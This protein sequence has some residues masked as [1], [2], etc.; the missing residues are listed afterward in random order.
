MTELPPE[1]LR[2][3]PHDQSA[4]GVRRLAAIMFTDIKDFS[5]RMERDE[6][7][8]M[9]MLQVHNTMMR[10]AVQKFSGVVVKT[11]GDAFL[12]SFN[13][14]VSAVQC[15]VE[16]QQKFHEYNFQFKSDD[17]RILV[18]IG[19]HLGDVIESGT[20]IFG[21]GVN[22]ASRI[23]SIAEVGGLNI[24]ESVYQQVKNKLNIRVINLGVPQLKG[25]SE[26]V[27]LYQVIIVPTDK[28]RGTIATNLYVARTILRRKKT[29]QILGASFAGALVIGSL[30]YFFLAP[31]TLPNSLAILPF[32]N[33]GDSLTDYVVDGISEDLT[34]FAAHKLAKVH[35][36]SYASTSIYKNTTQKEIEIAQK[37][38]VRFLL[39]GRVAIEQN[40]VVLHV[41]LTEPAVNN[42]PW[43]TTY[44]DVKEDIPELEQEMLSDLSAQ[45]TKTVLSKGA[46]VSMEAYEPYLIGLGDVRKQN[47]DANMR[48]IDAFKEA[49]GKDSAF[50]RAYIM[51]ASSEIINNESRYSLDE[52]WLE[53]ARQNLLKAQVIDSS[54][55]E[56]AAVWGRWYLAEGKRDQGIAYLK[57]AVKIDPNYIASYYL[58]GE[59]YT[60][61]L[62]DPVQGLQY[63][64]QA[65][66]IEPTDF[67][68]SMNVGIGYAVQKNY[69]EAINAFQRAAFIN[70]KHE[71]PWTNLGNLYT[72]TGQSDSAESAFR[73]ALQRNPGDLV[74]TEHLASLLL[75]KGRTDE[76]KRKLIESL[77]LNPSD[78][79]LLYTLGI[80]YSQAGQRDS[81][82]KVWRS[83][84]A[85]AENN[86]RTDS[87]LADHYTYAGLFA[88]RLGMGALA[89]NY[90]HTAVVKDSSEDNVLNLSK[91]FAI[92]GAK[93]DMIIW[94][95]RARAMDSEYGETFL[96]VD[97]DFEKYKTDPDLLLAARK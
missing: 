91:I 79:D 10:F 35:V 18:R 96:R 58:L 65:Y 80:A 64:Q 55:A 33:T 7:A 68:A 95:S 32:R 50:A 21:D 75:Q 46:A 17:D 51:C 81:A 29:K 3:D 92:M 93:N 25:I 47:K 70:P 73:S 89:M 78:Y 41:R 12:I 22:I 57:R 31:K 86:I 74:A 28:A 8:T 27:K 83:G 88:A 15:A 30:W 13:S 71:L 44:L 20:D 34:S 43:S 63:W 85:V 16:V 56:L 84:L 2:Q 66:Q 23:Q 26:P 40:N 45:L 6:Q 4:N 19:I 53:D 62:N 97:L 60:F 59:Q 1:N 36:L 42:D 24:S 49:I 54:S 72:L 39:V 67:N 37:L 61:D 90:G 77:K 69:P 38:G 14:V 76:A 94:F 52:K 5:K 48:S 11:V 9:R 87:G 82:A